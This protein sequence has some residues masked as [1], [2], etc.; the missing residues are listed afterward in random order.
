LLAIVVVIGWLFLVAS[1][2]THGD[3]PPPGHPPRLAL[4]PC[5]P[6]CSS[7]TVTPGVQR[8]TAGGSGRSV[9]TR[10]AWRV[11]ATATLLP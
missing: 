5:A 6:S 4:A 7:Y 11:A 2:Q 8:S 10:A 1:P 9:E 3:Q